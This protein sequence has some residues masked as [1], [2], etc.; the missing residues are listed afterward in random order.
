[1]QIVIVTIGT[2]GD[3]QPY[4]ALARG[5][6][7]AGHAV[8]IATHATFRTF[9]EMHG[10]GFAPL[11]G[12][13]RTLLASAAGRQ[14]LAQRNPLAAVRQLQALAAPLLRQVMADIIAASAGA[15]LLLGSTLG[16]LNAVTAAQVHRVPLVLAALQPFTPTAAFPSPLLAP[17]RQPFPGR[18]SV[19]RFTHL[20]SYRLLQLVA[21]RQANRYRRELTGLPALNFGDVFGDLVAQR[22][23]VLYGYSS[24]LLPRPADYGPALHVTG[25]WFL[26]RPAAWQPSAELAQFLARGAPPVYIGFGSMSDRA[27]EAVA[28]IAAEALQM[29]GQRGILVSG[30]EGLR[31]VH[32]PDNMLLIESAPHDWLFPRVAAVV[33]HGGVGTM[34]AALRAGVPQ[35]VVPFGADQ[36]LWAETLFQ[37][38]A[39]PV[40]LPRRRLTAPRL[41]SALQQA[42]RDPALVLATRRL[43]AALG[44]E[45]GVARA[46]QVIDG[47]A[48]CAATAGAPSARSGNWAHR[49]REAARV[50]PLLGQEEHG[51]EDDFES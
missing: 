21:A 31:S 33:H 49:V 45:H 5:L 28:R 22:S 32:V 7:A 37:R 51:H 42:Q 35:V 10:V 15:D 8:V 34:A 2:R 12:D 24:H 44:A 6:Q 39:A 38:G 18:G 3:V 36:P 26:D 9:V 11:A 19:H 43:A 50:A 4:I 29:T 30:W 13:I 25:F 41:A 27:P 23:P 47:M 20:A 1:M 16:Y 14:L 48:R 17:L 40:P 46:V